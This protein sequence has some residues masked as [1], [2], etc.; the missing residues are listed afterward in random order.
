MCGLLVVI[1]THSDVGLVGQSVFAL[2][3]N[4]VDV[5]ILLNLT[6]AGTSF[7][8]LFALLGVDFAR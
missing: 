1:Q 7:T 2:V 3:N 8:P 4:V 5:L 6:L